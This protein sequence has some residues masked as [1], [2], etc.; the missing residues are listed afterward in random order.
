METVFRRAAERRMLLERRPRREGLGGVDVPRG[1]L[2][3]EP[4][5]L[6]DV[7][8]THRRLSGDRIA[9]GIHRPMVEGRPQLQRHGKTLGPPVGPIDQFGDVES[10][11]GC[12]LEPGKDEEQAVAPGLPHRDAR[13]TED[14]LVGIVVGQLGMPQRRAARTHEPRTVD[15]A[16]K[17][18]G[19]A[20][21]AVTIDACP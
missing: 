21:H 1:C 15:H 11:E 12:V 3:L 10:E 6:G 5:P 13:Q 20:A 14:Q 9:D 8:A 16:T 18:P 4:G 17:S 2:R 7:R 19:P